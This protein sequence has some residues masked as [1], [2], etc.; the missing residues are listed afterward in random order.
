[1]PD[2]A[3]RGVREPAEQARQQRRSRSVPSPERGPRG[4]GSLVPQLPPLRFAPP[5]LIYSRER[6]QAPEPRR[7]SARPLPHLF[8]HCLYTTAACGLLPPS[9]ASHGCEAQA[10]VQTL[11]GAPRG[12]SLQPSGA[13]GRRSRGQGRLRC[14][15]QGWRRE[16]KLTAGSGKGYAVLESNPDRAASSAPKAGRGQGLSPRLT[17]TWGTGQ[18]P[19]GAGDAAFNPLP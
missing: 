4:R 1:M 13:C 2:A 16:E 12:I 8:R 11:R 9:C 6:S 5:A 3:R 19:S 10:H 15:S 14:C 17:G 7:C 18:S